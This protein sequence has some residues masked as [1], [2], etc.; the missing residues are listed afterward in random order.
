MRQPHQ[1]A[2]EVEERQRK[3]R[4]PTVAFPALLKETFRGCDLSAL[5]VE[6]S[7]GSE[8]VQIRSPLYGLTVERKSVVVAPDRLKRRG[9][10]R[11][12]NRGIR[13]EPLRHIEIGQ[14]LRKAM[15]PRTRTCSRKESQ[16]ATWGVID[17]LF[18]QLLSPL[19]IGNAS[20]D[21]P[22]QADEVNE[23]DSTGGSQ[24]SSPELALL[25]VDLRL[26]IHQRDDTRRRDE[27]TVDGRT[28]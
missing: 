20:E 2:L 18:C 24:P 12:E 28:R 25:A 8:G 27:L 17:E 16:A 19:V 21:L 4:D 3:W 1:T 15:E 26:Q 9:T 6:R 5:G 14:R 10:F 7:H 11:V 13:S 22:L 23:F